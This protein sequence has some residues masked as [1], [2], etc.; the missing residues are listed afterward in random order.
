MILHSDV[1]VTSVLSA[2]V[3]FHGQSLELPWVVHGSS[4]GVLTLVHFG[5]PGQ[6]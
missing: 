5:Q 6:S 3:L 2:G 1:C 4:M